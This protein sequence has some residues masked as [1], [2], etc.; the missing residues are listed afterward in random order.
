MYS[1]RKHD[2]LNF[3]SYNLGN[4]NVNDDN[5]DKLDHSTIS[6]VFLVKKFYGEKAARRRARNWKL[7]HMAEGML[8]GVS[9]TNE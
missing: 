4:S 9:S 8:D 6:D 2:S 1:L 7:K 5:F 3:S